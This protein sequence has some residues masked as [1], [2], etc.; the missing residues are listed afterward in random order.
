MTRYSIN[1]RAGDLLPRT[2]RFR[3]PGTPIDIVRMIKSNSK[4]AETIK[5]FK[6]LSN[7]NP[8]AEKFALAERLKAFSCV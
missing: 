7:P 3:K 6:S 8:F 5:K 2:K 4:V 1:A